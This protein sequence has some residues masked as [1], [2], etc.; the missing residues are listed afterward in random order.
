M[1]T[2]QGGV[3]AVLI[4]DE[5]PV[6]YALK[7]MNETQQRWTQIEKELFAVLFACKHFHQCVYGKPVIV[8]SDHRPLEFIFRKPLSQA[9][10]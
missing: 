10:P 2:S 3:E 4:Q 9:P 7:A 8:E 5:G 6:G 1:D